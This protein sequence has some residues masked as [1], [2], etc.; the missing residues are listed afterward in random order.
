MI[1]TFN[2]Q[3]Y[4]R[5]LWVQVGKEIPEGFSDV[6]EFSN[7]ADAQVDYCHDDKNNKGG[8][9]IRFESLNAMNVGVI[10]H[11][12]VHV[13]IEILQYCDIKLDADNSEVLCYLS[14]WIAKCCGE[15]AMKVQET[16][17]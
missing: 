16:I 4:P 13:A 2:P 9:L 12:A 7:N 10:T 11:E 5:L 8:V 17:G 1:Y 14:G 3:I 15:A 6:A